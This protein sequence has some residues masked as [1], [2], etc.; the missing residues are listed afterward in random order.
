[1]PA[2]LLN[3]LVQLVIK[4]GLPALIKRF[5]GLPAELW[6]LIEEILRHVAGSGN[7]SAAT[8][9][10]RVKVKECTGAGCPI[11]TVK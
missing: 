7:P 2:W 10:L 4:L 11:D 1:M 6:A 3:L 5:P 8:A 9:L